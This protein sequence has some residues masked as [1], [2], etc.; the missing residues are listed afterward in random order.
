M[1]SHRAQSPVRSLVLLSALLTA[2]CS[3]SRSSDTAEAVPP[4][5]PRDSAGASST[6]LAAAARTIVEFLRGDVGFEAIRLADTV[7]LYL[8]PEG[9]GTHVR[10]PREH[11]AERSSWSIR[12]P[13][14]STYTLAP[15]SGQLT[16]AAG[17]HFNCLEY[18]LSS[19]FPELASLPHAGVRIMPAHDASCLQSWNLTLVFAPNE[20]RPTL[21]AAVYDQW[22]W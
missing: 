2:G 21:I 11:L 9:G 12:S 14:G 19:R 7:T 3:D 1:I 5:Q 15:P 22:E 16:A 6:E 8:S 20:R 17:V 10:V 4:A 13:E 18:A